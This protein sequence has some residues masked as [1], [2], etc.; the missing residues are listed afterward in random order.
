MCL[1]ATLT[2]VTYV[3][4]MSWMADFVLVQSATRPR[5]T[6]S[7]SRISPHSG[8]GVC[9]LTSSSASMIF[10]SLASI[11]SSSTSFIWERLL[12]LF[13]ASLSA[14]W[15]SLRISASSCLRLSFSCFSSS[16]SLENFFSVRTFSVS[17]SVTS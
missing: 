2:P 13:S 11:S 17:F 10:W 4:T 16:I 15:L 5:R 12:I 1:D 3:S 6:S 7:P 9:A 8:F 14:F